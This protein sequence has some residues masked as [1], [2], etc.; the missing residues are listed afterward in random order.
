[1]TETS[2]LR[3]GAHVEQIDPIA[4]ATARNAPLVQ[5]FLGNPQRLPAR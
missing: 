4:E 2:A 5:F 1:M 3:I